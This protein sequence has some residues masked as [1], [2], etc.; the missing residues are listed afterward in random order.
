MNI[1][2]KIRVRNDRIRFSYSDLYFFLYNS[3]IPDVTDNTITI[4]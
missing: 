2:I 3:F 4:I 1:K